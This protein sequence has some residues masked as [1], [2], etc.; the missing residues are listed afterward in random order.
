MC[1]LQYPVRYLL[2]CLI[3][4]IYWVFGNDFHDIHRF[5]DKVRWKVLDKSRIDR[6]ASLGQFVVREVPFG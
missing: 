3:S 5:V 1:N 6:D 2:K 4:A